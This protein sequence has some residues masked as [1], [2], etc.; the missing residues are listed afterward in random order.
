MPL[1][2]AASRKSAAVIYFRILPRFAGS[3]VQVQ[4]YKTKTRSRNPFLSGT[5]SSKLQPQLLLFRPTKC[6]RGQFW[7][8]FGDAALSSCD[9][10]H[11]MNLIRQNPLSA[12]A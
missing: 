4:G 1:G 3:P 7:S 10:E 2:I 12:H 9:D 11:L 6:R 8:V 5:G